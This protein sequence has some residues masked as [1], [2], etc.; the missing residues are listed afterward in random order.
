MHASFRLLVLVSAT[1]IVSGAVA[2]PAWAG[3]PAVIARQIDQ[4]IQQRL[5]EEK[6]PTSLSADDAEFLRR[7]YLDLTGRIPTYDQ[8]VAFLNSK[9]PDKRAQLIEELLARP[10][11]GLH[12]A[13]V[14]RDLLVDRSL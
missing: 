7:V 3:E 4:Q 8:A 5:D 12:F 1:L 6:L 13:T 14:W 11:Y 2:S 9:A 10:E